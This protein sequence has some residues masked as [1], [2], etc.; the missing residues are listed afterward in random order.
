MVVEKVQTS[1]L[2]LMNDEADPAGIWSGAS[3][4]WKPDSSHNNANTA[5][6]WV[7]EHAVR[8]RDST[9]PVRPASV[10]RTLI[11]DSYWLWG[12]GHVAPEVKGY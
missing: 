2:E 12:P 8:I 7:Q 9:L 6:D 4:L 5:G 11:K 1:P 3:R 10:T